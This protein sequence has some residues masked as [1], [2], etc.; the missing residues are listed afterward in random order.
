MHSPRLIYST[1]YILLVCLLL[2]S[3]V[4]IAAKKNKF[5]LAK[6]SHE[7]LST[8]QELIQNNKN[9]EAL[10][11]LNNLLNL[12]KS[13]PYDK[14]VTLQTM[15][16]VYTALN[17]Q[18]KA[19]KAFTDSIKLGSL[20]KSITHELQFTV[21]QILI[22]KG[23]NK[24]GLKHLSKWFRQEKDPSPQAHFLAATAYYFVKDYKQLIYQLRN[25]FKKQ[26]DAPASWYELLLAGY[27]ETEET[28]NSSGDP[29]QKS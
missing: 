29:R 12:T 11:I 19:L 24:E 9:K 15:G 20:P 14:A 26:K 6:L 23:D 27:Y 22:H 8:V 10:S 16:F 4:T 2:Q 28:D 3:Q 18:D 17:Q 25:A 7:K 1:L 21:A 13:K 5:E